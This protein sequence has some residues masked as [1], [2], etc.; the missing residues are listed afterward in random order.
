MSDEPRRRHLL[1]RAA[2]LAAGIVAAVALSVVAIGRTR[3]AAGVGPVT[4][5]TRNDDIAVERR[6]VPLPLPA[7]LAA[8]VAVF[9]LVSFVALALIY[10]RALHGPSDAPRIVTAGPR[11]EVNPAGDLAAFRAGEQ[12]ALG[13][14]GWIDRAHGV[15]RIPIDQAM[16]DVAAGG[17]KDW[18]ED[19]K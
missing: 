6:D 7:A 11:L 16:H 13:S 12:R 17:I 15:V 14:Y 19:A 2:V 10:P 1:S 9:L 3:H 5:G 4:D 18:P 8:G